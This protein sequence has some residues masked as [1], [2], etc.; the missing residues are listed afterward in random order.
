MKQALWAEEEETAAKMKQAE[1][2]A[3]KMKQARCVEEEDTA[4]AVCA[5]EAT[6]KK[7]QMGILQ[8]RLALEVAMAPEVLAQQTQAE[9]AE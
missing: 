8:Q 4:A 6:A 5:A 3:A 9:R 2:A 7:F 1:E